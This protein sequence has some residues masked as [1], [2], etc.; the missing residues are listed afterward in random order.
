MVIGNRTPDFNPFTEYDR[1]FSSLGD[2]QDILVL[3]VGGDWSQANDN[4]IAFHTVD[5]QY[6]NTNGL[7][8]YAA[9]LAT[10]RD[11]RTNQGVAPA[12]TMIWDSR[13][14]PLIS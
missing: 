2:K 6:N 9:Y 11:L 5:A 12:T 10:Y 14:R 1:Q 4:N 7:S 8:L 13:A 3:G